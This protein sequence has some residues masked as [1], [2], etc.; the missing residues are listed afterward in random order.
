MFIPLLVPVFVNLVF[1]VLSCFKG[2]I[3]FFDAQNFYHRGKLFFITPVICFTFLLFTL[4]FII[5]KQKKIEEKFLIPVIAFALLP[6]IGGILQIM[7]YG[8]SLIWVSMTISILIVFMNLQSNQLYIDY[9]TGLYNRRYLDY[10]LQERLK[11]AKRGNLL[12]AAMIDL[13][14][15]KKINDLW[16]HSVG[17]RALMEAGKILTMSVR[18]NDLVCRYGGDEFVV[19]FEI[20]DEIQL[21]ASISKIREN[22]KRFNEK[23][24][25]PFKISFSMGYDLYDCWS[26]TPVQRFLEH[27]DGLMYADKKG[28]KRD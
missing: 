7:F 14:S 6:L 5:V 16:G 12:A 19:I 13:N 8:V 3:F 21:S 2:Y 17:D 1:S 24:T 22:A 27:I 20:K 9:L 4:A 28:N 11:T 23:K 25:V 18:K 26:E 10:Y 15:F